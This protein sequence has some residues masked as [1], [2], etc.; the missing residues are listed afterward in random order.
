[1]VSTLDAPVPRLVP[2]TRAVVDG[3]IIQTIYSHWVFSACIASSIPRSWSSG[4]P[5]TSF[6]VYSSSASA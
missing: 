3:S 5:W 6:C 2:L 1:M 4:M